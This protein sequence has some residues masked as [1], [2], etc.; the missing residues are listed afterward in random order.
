MGTARFM[1]KA[2]DSNGQQ[3]SRPASAAVGV[4]TMHTGRQ[5]DRQADRQTKRKAERTKRQT[6]RQTGR[7]KH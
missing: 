7:V 2:I 1:S 6:D 5:T 3:I 4:R